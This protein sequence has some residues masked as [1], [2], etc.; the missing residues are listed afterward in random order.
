MYLAAF[1]DAL[2]AAMR[3]DDGV[4]HPRAHAFALRTIAFVPEN[5]RGEARKRLDA[6][7]APASAAAASS[8]R[9]RV[10]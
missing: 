4:L 6:V 1:A 10:S 5:L 3:R 9:A 7:F 2:A 8:K